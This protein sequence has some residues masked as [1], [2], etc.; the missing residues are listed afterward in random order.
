MAGEFKIMRQGTAQHSS[1]HLH[2]R[3]ARCR[4][5]G[6]SW[7]GPRTIKDPRV[8]KQ[9]AKHYWD[10]H[11]GNLDRM[12]SQLDLEAAWECWSHGYEEILCQMA[13][14]QLPK[15]GEDSSRGLDS[16]MRTKR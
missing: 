1:V 8:D 6:H 4:S 13:G 5:I 9:F 3:G 7:E 11:E 16:M 10:E 12:V 2:L 14:Q 15:F